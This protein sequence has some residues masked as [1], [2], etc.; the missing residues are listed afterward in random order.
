MAIKYPSKMLFTFT[1]MSGLKV[2]IDVMEIVAVDDMRD[3]RLIEMADQSTY[4]VLE[5]LEYITEMVNKYKAT[6][7]YKSY[8]FN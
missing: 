5:S 1:K 8:F 3:H 2:S 4:E 6:H 7:I